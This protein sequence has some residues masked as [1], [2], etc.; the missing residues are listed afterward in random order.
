MKVHE[1]ASSFLDLKNRRDEKK[2]VIEY[3]LPRELKALE[4]QNNNVDG[5]L[6]VLDF[7]D[8]IKDHTYELDQLN[9]ELKEVEEDLKPLLIEVKAMRNDPLRI[10][11]DGPTHFDT[12]L[13]EG[14]IISSGH[15]H[16]GAR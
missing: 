16:L 5:K 13:E 8:K 11:V 2:R 12:F 10:Q 15:F 6:R 1:L 4:A 3:D 14:E 9:K 7:M